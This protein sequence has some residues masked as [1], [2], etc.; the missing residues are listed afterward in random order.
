MIDFID[1]DHNS[2]QF[3]IHDN[4]IDNTRH[5]SSTVVITDPFYTETYKT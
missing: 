4:T 1:I 3:T 5:T 2:Q